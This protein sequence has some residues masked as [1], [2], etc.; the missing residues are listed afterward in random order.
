MKKWSEENFHFGGS[1]RR[2]LQPSPFLVTGVMFNP[3]ECKFSTY[4]VKITEILA[5]L[6]TWKRIDV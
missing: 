6:T 2:G 5:I 4:L 1:E 3:D